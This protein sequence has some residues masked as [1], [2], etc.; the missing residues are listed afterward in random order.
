MKKETLI[1]LI[2][3]SCWLMY[4]KI[5]YFANMFKET[6]YYVKLIVETVN[7]S[8][9]FMAIYVIMLICFGNGIMVLNQQRDYRDDDNSLYPKE[10]GTEPMDAL[11]HIFISSM[12]EFSSDNYTLDERERVIWIFFIVSTYMTTII[13]FNMLINIMGL[14]LDRLEESKERIS[15]Q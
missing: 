1:T 10:V 8:K 13:F 15:T 7:E 14:T 11:L 2:S 4:I 12:G 9:V 3:I 5:I 6:G